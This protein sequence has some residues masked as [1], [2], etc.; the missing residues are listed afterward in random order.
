[1]TLLRQGPVVIVCSKVGKGIL[2]FCSGD[3]GLESFWA[4]YGFRCACNTG[5]PVASVIAC[6]KESTLPVPTSTLR[7]WMESISIVMMMMQLF[8]L[9]GSDHA[10]F[11]EGNHK[12]RVELKFPITIPAP[13]EATL[14]HSN[15]LVA[16]D[17]NDPLAS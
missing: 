9:C 5:Y 15:M 12:A 8:L 3:H 13:I 6:K 11:R 2:P 17:G 1:M 7:V 4:I 10:G 16:G 14:Q